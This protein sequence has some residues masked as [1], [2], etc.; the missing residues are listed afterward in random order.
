MLR[1][2]CL[3][4][5]L[6]LLANPVLAAAPTTD[7]DWPCKQRLVPELTGATLW[8][9]PPLPADGKWQSDKRVAA[10]VV[11]VS[12]RD[13]PIEEGRVQ[14]G[15]FVDG[16]KPAERKTILPE[17]FAGIVDEVNRQRDAIITRIR[18]LTHRQRDIGDVVSKVTTELQQIPEDAQGADA[19]RREEIVQRRGY[20]I[21]AFEEAERTMRY[22]CEAPVDL[23]A[24][25]GDYARL[26]QDR[27]GG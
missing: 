22:A 13:L 12:S 3:A 7:A 17:V 11:A 9:G 27:L 6:I 23:E 18:E 8:N 26:L 4:S 10:I 15:K 20:V 21:R 5:T 2:A 14:L 24:R 1:L 25:L 16:V 19:Q